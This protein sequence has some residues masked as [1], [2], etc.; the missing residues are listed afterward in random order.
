MILCD[1][2]TFRVDETWLMP[3]GPNLTFSSAPPIMSLAEREK[4]AIESVLRETGGLVS[5][6]AGAAAKLGIPRQTLEYKI[7]KFGI[8]P[9][10]FKT[11]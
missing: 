9:H 2:E 7:R 3:V 6:P 4:A 5:G 1:G 10:Q 8:N 11:L